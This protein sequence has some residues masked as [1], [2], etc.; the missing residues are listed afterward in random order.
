L[1]KGD[2]AMTSI[3]FSEDKIEKDGIIIKSMTGQP[4]SWFSRDISS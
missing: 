1:G 4:L 2:K 3:N